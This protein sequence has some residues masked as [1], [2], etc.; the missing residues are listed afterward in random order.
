[1]SRRAVPRPLPEEWLRYCFSTISAALGKEAEPR[2]PASCEGLSCALFVTLDK[3]SHRSG[4]YEL[5]GCIGNFSPGPL[6]DMLRRY[7]L[8]SAFRDSRFDPVEADELPLLRVGLSIITDVE[9]APGGWR[10]WEVGKHGIIIDFGGADGREY[11]GTF[12]PMVAEENGWDHKTT[13][14]RLVRKAGFRGP[15]NAA[16][17]D[18]LRVQRYQVVKG[19][20]E[21]ASQQQQQ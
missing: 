10:D 1:M 3:L 5:R 12:L 2:A 6:G 18:S 19:R 8:H 15:V 17:R 20:L 14:D 4:A 16:L 11:G 9:P 7:S 13:V 21:Y